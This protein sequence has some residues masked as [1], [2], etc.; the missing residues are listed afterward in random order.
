VTN[1]E[2]KIKGRIPNCGGS[3]IGYQLLPKM[4]LAGVTVLNTAS[5]SLSK[6]KKIRITKNIEAN[7]HIRISFSIIN[8]F[9]LRI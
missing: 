2:P 7:P 6:N 3:E 8:S 9:S 5:P 4:K 1:S